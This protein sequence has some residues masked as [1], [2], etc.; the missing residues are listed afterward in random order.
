MLVMVSM[1][2]ALD[3]WWRWRTNEGPFWLVLLIGVV[4]ALSFSKELV[5]I[6]LGI[7][8]IDPL[9][10]N[11]NRKIRGMIVILMAGLF[12]FGTH[13]IVTTDLSSAQEKLEGTVYSSQKVI[14]R[15]CDVTFIES[16]YLA[17]KHAGIFVGL[18]HPILGVGPGRFNHAIQ[19][20]KTAGVYPEFLPDYDPHSTWVGAFSEAGILGLISLLFLA[21]AFYRLFTRHASMLQEQPFARILLVGLLLHVIASVSVDA[22]NFR[23]VWVAMGILTGLALPLRSST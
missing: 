5:L 13:V 12:W 6:G 23:H 9:L 22:M 3:A 19:E 15:C 10:Q 7:F 11:V 17:L 1:I 20:A 18:E 21:F 2:M 4:L 16:S 14:G 8:L